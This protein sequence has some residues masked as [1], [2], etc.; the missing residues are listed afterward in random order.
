VNILWSRSG[1]G[2]SEKTAST[3]NFA[4]R[5]FKKTDYQTYMQQITSF[6][7]YFLTR[8][9]GNYTSGQRFALI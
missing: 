5:A 2:S 7:C 1:G 8:I 4:R 3:P 9:K 6:S